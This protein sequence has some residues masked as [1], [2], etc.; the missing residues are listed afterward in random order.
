MAQPPL[1]QV[2]SNTKAP[3]NISGPTAHLAMAA[4]EPAALEGMRTKIRT[5]LESREKLKASLEQLT[6]LGV[7]KSIGGNEANFLMIPILDPATGKPDN[8]RSYNVYKTLAEDKGADESCVVVRYRGG[9]P[10]C[11]ACL[12]ITVGSEAENEMLLKR[13]AR[14][15]VVCWPPSGGSR[16]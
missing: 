6:H 11:E 9:E 5:L 15:L 2:L 1:I 16:A 4:L 7:G 8:A 14:L 13:L 12:R 10:G 3:Y